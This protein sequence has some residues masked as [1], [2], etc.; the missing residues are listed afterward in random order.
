MVDHM[1]AHNSVSSRSN[2]KKE[3]LNRGND[4]TDYGQPTYQMFLTPSLGFYLKS[5]ET[6]ENLYIDLG[7]RF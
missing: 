5:I 7:T 6:D 4:S 1:L 2:R 3:T